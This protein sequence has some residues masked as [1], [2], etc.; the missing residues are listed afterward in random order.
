MDDWTYPY[1]DIDPPDT[2]SALLDQEWRGIE[3][4]RVRAQQAEAALI[5]ELEQTEAMVSDLHADA[6]LPVPFGVP[7]NPLTF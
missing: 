4:R 1:P 5:A 7:A 6:H 2:R 3:A